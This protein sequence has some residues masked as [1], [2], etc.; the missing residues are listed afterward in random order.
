LSAS[1]WSEVERTDHD[2]DE[3]NPHDYSFIRLDRM[4]PVQA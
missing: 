3:N 1:E 4:H 2:P